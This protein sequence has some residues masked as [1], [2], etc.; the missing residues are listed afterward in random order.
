MT[1]AVLEAYTDAH[2]WQ[3]WSCLNNNN[4]LICCYSFDMHWGL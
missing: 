2:M 3:G 4:P 1:T